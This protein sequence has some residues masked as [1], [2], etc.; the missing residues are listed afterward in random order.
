MSSHPQSVPSGRRTVDTRHLP[1]PATLPLQLQRAHTVRGLTHSALNGTTL[2]CFNFL[3]GKNHLRDFTG[4]VALALPAWWIFSKQGITLNQWRGPDLRGPHWCFSSRNIPRLQCCA[5]KA[6]PSL[7]VWVESS[8]CHSG[9]T[10]RS[11][12]LFPPTSPN[13]QDYVQLRI[14]D[15]AVCASKKRPLADVEVHSVTSSVCKAFFVLVWR[16]N[17]KPNPPGSPQLHL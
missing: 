9:Y 1:N 12:P 5:H 6:V 17:W 11:S 16:E 13:Y 7:D 15:K 4:V 10:L 3:S 2:Q 14:R 8:C